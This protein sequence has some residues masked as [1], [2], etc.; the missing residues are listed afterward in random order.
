MKLDQIDGRTAQRELSG[1][2]SISNRTLFD[3][4][5]INTSIRMAEFLGKLYIFVDKAP[6]GELEL[7]DLP[8]GDLFDLRRPGEPLW[9]LQGWAVGNNPRS[10]YCARTSKSKCRTFSIFAE[11]MDFVRK[12]RN[13]R[14]DDKFFLVYGVDG[15]EFVVNGL[16]EIQAI[17]RSLADVDHFASEHLERREH[18]E[19]LTHKVGKIVATNALTLLR[20]LQRYG[21]DAARTRFSAATYARLWQVLRDAGLVQESDLRSDA[22]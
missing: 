22:T 16:D 17:D 10:Q 1:L 19:T 7:T 18:F 4:R 21:E 2:A 6:D 12:K 9:F 5:P 13:A 15:R 11:A 14:P 8:R 20:D 3:R